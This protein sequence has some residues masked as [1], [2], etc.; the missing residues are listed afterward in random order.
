MG[1]RWVFFRYM[2]VGLYVGFATVGIFVF[3]FLYY[4]DFIAFLG[5]TVMELLGSTHDGH[6]MITYGQLT[7]WGQCRIG[8]DAA[9]TIFEDFQVNNFDYNRD[10]IVDDFSTNPCLYFSKGKMQASTLSL[11]VLVTIEMFNALNAI[12]E[13]GSLL[14]IPPWVNPWLLVAMASSFV[15]HFVILYVPAMAAV[16]SIA[17]HNGVEWILVFLFSFPV[18]ILDEILK[19]V[20]RMRN[21]AERKERAEVKDKDL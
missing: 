5:P 20:G 13:D 12:S 3:W 1:N 7:H 17:P 10:G 18:I 14:K 2:V 21:E 4:D 9:G 8:D 19:Y 16:F 11:S 6:S 15:L